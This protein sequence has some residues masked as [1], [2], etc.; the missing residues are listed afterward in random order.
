MRPALNPAVY[1]FYLNDSNMII[2]WFSQA[3]G[4]QH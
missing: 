4:W 3:I 1:R 2:E